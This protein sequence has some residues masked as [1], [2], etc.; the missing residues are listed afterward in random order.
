M[1]IVRTRGLRSRNLQ[2]SR[3]LRTPQARQTPGKLRRHADRSCWPRLGFDRQVTPL[4]SS[5]DTAWKRAGPTTAVGDLSRPCSLRHW[6]LVPAVSDVC[7]Q[8][9]RAVGIFDHRERFEGT[10]RQTKWET[11]AFLGTRHFDALPQTGDAR[12]RKPACS[13][14]LRRAS[15]RFERPGG[16]FPNLTAPCASTTF[17][18]DASEE[19]FLSVARSSLRQQRVE[20]P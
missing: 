16:P 6:S 14:C 18:C 12:Q 15:K 2:A 3:R 10:W 1:A 5:A 4:L 11:C 20:E 13:A 7:F 8:D 17:I 19:S 9:Q